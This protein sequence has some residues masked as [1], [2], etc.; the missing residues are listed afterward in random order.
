MV[1]EKLTK[2]DLL[3][4]FHNNHLAL[5]M[6]ARLNIKI[7]EKVPPEHIVGASGKMYGMSIL[8]DAKQSMKEENRKLKVNLEILKWIEE[9]RNE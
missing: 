8:K 3:N 5:A 2:N 4:S 9:V 7:L 6:K 1:I